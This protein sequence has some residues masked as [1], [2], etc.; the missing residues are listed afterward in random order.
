MNSLAQKCDLSQLQKEG[1]DFDPWP[2]ANLHPT[3]RACTF[4]MVPFDAGCVH[5]FKSL[6]S[7]IHTLCLIPLYG[8][9]EPANNLCLSQSER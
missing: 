3:A 5:E 6:V 9:S 7:N 2:S 1:N 4:L 8:I